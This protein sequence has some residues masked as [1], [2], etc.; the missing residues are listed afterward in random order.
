MEWK[1]KVDGRGRGVG[2]NQA[3]YDWPVDQMRQWV[4][5]DLLTHKEIGKRL[6][7]NPKL[8]SK[9]CKRFGIRCQRRGPRGGEGHPEW[10]GGRNFDKHGYILVHRPGHP[11]ARKMG[12]GRKAAY[13]PEHRLVM[14]EFLGRMLE[15]GEVVHHKNSDVTDNRIENLELYTSNGQHLRDE[16]AGRCPNWSPDG[17]QRLRVAR[18]R[19]N[20]QAIL[21]DPTIN[22]AVKL[23]FQFHH[24]TPIGIDHPLPF[25]MVDEPKQ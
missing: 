20:I 4:E 19:G 12:K 2:K 3:G 6:G 16:L 23:Q 11:M 22:D 17:E 15:P 9:A 7:V 10:K 8:V 24:Q 13:V 21:L 25:G 14:A 1:P 18:H 5:I